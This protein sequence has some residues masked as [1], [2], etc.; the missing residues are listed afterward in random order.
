MKKEIQEKLLQIVRQ[1]YEEIAEDFNET[2]KKQFWPELVKLAAE[3]KDGD[4][5]LDVG[6]GNGRLIAAFKDRKINYIGVDGN[7]KLISLARENLAAKSPLDKGG[8]GDFPKTET[9]HNPP[10]SRGQISPAET[11]PRQGGSNFQFLVGDILE[12]DKVTQERFDWIFCI[13]VLHHI[14]GEDLR[15]SALEQM[16]NRLK[17]GGKIVLTVWNLWT[18]PKYLKLIIKFSALKL[19]GRNQMDW[20]DLVFNWGAGKSQ[21]YY[22]AFTRGEF[23]RLAGKTGLKIERLYKDKFNYY[24][25]LV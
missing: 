25:M 19:I 15:V 17:P 11:G 20:D 10:L 18:Q 16:K 8:W 5:I 22:H 24:L 12:L 3:V 7:E 13:A 2:R 1:N 9:P 4:S 14:P 23:K 6:C 21:R